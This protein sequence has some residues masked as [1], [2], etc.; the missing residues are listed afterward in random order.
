MVPVTIISND[1]ASSSRDS[2]KA[3]IQKIVESS[4]PQCS[5]SPTISEEMSTAPTSTSSIYSDHDEPSTCQ[6]RATGAT[7]TL[8]HKPPSVPESHPAPQPNSPQRHVPSACDPVPAPGAPQTH[9]PSACARTESVEPASQ[10]KLISS[11]RLSLASFVSRLFSWRKKEQHEPA[12]AKAREDDQRDSE[13][14]NRRSA[15]QLLPLRYVGNTMRA[16]T[17]DDFDQL[18]P[19]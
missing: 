7:R 10:P 5:S 13:R 1:G 6:P 17:I 14:L 3:K 8:A 12:L 11:L 18:T 19:S 15:L 4:P 9:V 16:I 2:G